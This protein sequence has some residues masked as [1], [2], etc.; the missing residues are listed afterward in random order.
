MSYCDKEQDP[1]KPSDCSGIIMH[2]VPG[3]PERART[4]THTS[5]DHLHWKYLT[6]SSK[7]FSLPDLVA[8]PVC[9]LLCH[10]EVYRNIP[11]SAQPSYRDQANGRAQ[12]PSQGPSTWEENLL[13][14]TKLIT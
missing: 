4:H 1:G 11:Q 9:S 7:A 10:P 8:T 3:H 14:L 12:E 6:H 2:S 13:L 5:L